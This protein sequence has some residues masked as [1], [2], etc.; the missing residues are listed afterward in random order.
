MSI[1]LQLECPECGAVIT[2]DQKAK[3]K[4]FKKLDPKYPARMEIIPCKCGKVQFAIGMRSTKH[5]TRGL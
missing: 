2:I 1:P 5:D 3:D 4:I